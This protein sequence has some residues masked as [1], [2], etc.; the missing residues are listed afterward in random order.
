VRDRWD[1]GRIEAFS[2]GI[3]SVA[4]TLLVLEISVPQADFDHL[5]RGIGD[6]WPS[7]LAYATSFLTV[8][9]IWL[10]HHAIFRSLRF[11]DAI[12]TRLNLILLMAVAFLPF[13][14]KLVAEAIDSHDAERAAVIFYGATLLVISVLVTALVRYAGSQPEL[15]EEEGRDDAVALAAG[16][17]P[18]LGLYVVV[19]ALAFIA[20]KVAA[21]GF[22]AIALFMIMRARGKPR[23]KIMRARGEPRPK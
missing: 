7:Y 10:T 8:G 12:V 2:D 18:A 19:L 3:F 21:F 1:T 9:G 5:W 22:L 15:I 14:T 16:A 11:A 4:A 17:R 20:P 23:P 6:Q 13:P